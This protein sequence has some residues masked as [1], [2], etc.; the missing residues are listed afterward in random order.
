MTMKSNEVRIGDTIKIAEVTKD[1]TFEWDG[2]V[3]AV[4]SWGYQTKHSRNPIT[5]PYWFNFK[6]AYTEITTN[7]FNDN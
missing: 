3:T 4:E 6:W 5:H 7:H 2:V 1:G